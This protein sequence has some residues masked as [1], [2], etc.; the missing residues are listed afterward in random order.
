MG[1]SLPSM[2]ENSYSLMWREKR[3][4]YEG[5]SVI[6]HSFIKYKLELGDIMCGV[7]FSVL[8][9]PLN[10]YSFILMIH[11]CLYLVYWKYYLERLVQGTEVLR[12]TAR[13]PN[14]H[15]IITVGA[16]LNESLFTQ[17]SQ[18]SWKYTKLSQVHFLKISWDQIPNSISYINVPFQVNF[19][20]VSAVFQEV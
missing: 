1:G 18:D 7:C 16:L 20:G 9:W 15:W 12:K 14:G 13:S 3:V 6:A 2:L 5:E 11:I 10:K 19:P 17:V 8:K 4:I